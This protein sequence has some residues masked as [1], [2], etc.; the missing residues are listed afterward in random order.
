MGYLDADDD[1]YLYLA[2]RQAHMIISGGVNIYPQEAENLL[3]AHAAVADVAVLGVPDEEMGE[4]VKA[5][6][7]LV[8]PAAAGAGLAAE[9]IACCRAELAAYKCPRTVDF[10][11][12]LPRDPSGK[13]YKRQLRAQY[14]EGHDTLVS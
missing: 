8:D 3:A 10:V 2:D 9:L 4:A 11:V 1:G 7:Q 5:V 13:L 12:E 14:W 6:V